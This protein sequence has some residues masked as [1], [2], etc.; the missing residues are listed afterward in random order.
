MPVLVV[1]TLIGLT[2]AARLVALLG[3]RPVTHIVAQPHL[4]D[5]DTHAPANPNSPQTRKGQTSMPDDTIPTTTAPAA[6]NRH[7]RLVI[8]GVTV[9][10]LLIT[11]AAAVATS[12]T[13]APAL[14]TTRQGAV[15][16]ASTPPPQ[17]PTTGEQLLAAA[18]RLTAAPGD[19]T[20]GRYEYRHTRTWMLTTTGRP[21]PRPMTTIVTARDARSWAAVD[22]SGIVTTVEPDPDYT[23]AGA[24]PGY[25]STDVE[26]RDQ[27]A[28]T[29]R[30][31]AGELAGS[32]TGAIPTDPTVLARVLNALDPSRTG[33]EATMIDVQDLYS[34]RYVPLPARVAVLRM[35]AATSG[36]TF[37]ERVTDRLGRT[38]FAVSLDTDTR[39]APALRHRLTFDP[40][41][42]QLLA[43][44]QDLT[45]R[46]PD[47]KVP[48]GR[49][50]LYQLFIDQH[51]SN[52]VPN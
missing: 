41:T 24:D 21:A 25:R 20:S 17:P 30:H 18:D 16:S 4:R 11:A 51:R 43:Y 32:L 35:L 13:T 7:P 5:A 31:P 38:G 39:D 49:V 45:A 37:H 47:L 48:A 8:A 29:T 14:P 36:L 46:E 3:P 10:L 6:S 9:S 12:T 27:K 28:T 50:Y 52:T 40:V 19:Q 44:Q 15:V 34:A 22:G 42:G 26:F 2:L 33:P 1:A 23:L